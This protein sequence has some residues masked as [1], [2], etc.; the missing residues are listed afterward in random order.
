MIKTLYLIVIF[1]AVLGS[2]CKKAY[3]PNLNSPVTGYLVVEGFINSGGD[4][5]TITL[6]R[7]SKLDDSAFIVYEHN[8]DVFI[9]SSNNETFRLTEGSNGNYTSGMLQVHPN[10]KYRVRITTTDGKEYLSDF[11][12]VRYTPALDSISW[13]L[14]NDGVQI[15]ANSHDDQNNTKFYRWTYSETW[16]FH[17]RYLKTLY[18]IIDPVSQQA[19]DVVRGPADTT[20]Y[21]CWR[22]Q[23]STSIIS[24]SSEKLSMDKIHLPVRFIEPQSD[25]LTVLYY[26]Q[27]RQY[28][29]SHEAYL[30]Y[31]KLKKNTE[32][33]GSIFDPMPSELGGNMHCINDPNQ[34]VIGYVEV[35]QAQEKELFIR[36]SDLP[37]L[38]I[39]QIPCGEFEVENKPPLDLAVVPTRVA[40]VG[41][42]NT[43]ATFYASDAVCVDCTVRGT[44]KKPS[45]W[46]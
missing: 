24:G 19:I 36:N 15:Y 23:N 16:E 26:I 34:T 22:T 35:T 45:F 7:T 14:E 3:Q 10:S 8:A 17:S 39:S 4:I 42:F 29:L 18:Y 46:P 9:E 1:L 13:Q 32:Q 20:I 40:T 30:F 11:S 2:A 25:E 43:I 28:A 37:V 5:S 33:L 12:D 31:Q 41:P 44:N 6:S 27:L 21:K 38:W